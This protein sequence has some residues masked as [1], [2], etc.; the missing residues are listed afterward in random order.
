MTQTKTVEVVENVEDIPPGPFKTQKRFLKALLSRQYLYLMFG[1]AVRCGKTYVGLGVLDDMCTKYPGVRC[2]VVRK[3]LSVIRRNTIPSFK[4]ILRDYGDPK[5]CELNKAE[6]TYFYTNGSELLF[7]EGDIGSDPDLNKFRGFEATI[8]LLEEANEMA[9]AVFYKAIERTGQWMNNEYNIP[10]LVILT[11]NPDKNW[12]KTKFYDPWQNGQL[13]NPEFPDFEKFFFIQSLPQDNPYNSKMYL[14][15]LKAF[16]PA[17]YNRFVKGDWN[18]SDNP[19]QLIRYEWYS[20]CI[21]MSIPDDVLSGARKPKYIG[22]DVA[23]EGDDKTAL[24]YGD[25]NGLLYIEKYTH[26][27][28]WQTG[29][30]VMLRMAELGIPQENIGV[31]AIGVGA[32]VLGYLESKHVYIYSFKSTDGPESLPDDMLHF[33]FRNKRAEAHWL[34]RTAIQN[35]TTDLPPNYELQKQLCVLSY[36]T[37][38]GKITVVDKKTVKNELTYSPDEGDSFVIMHYV[39]EKQNSTRVALDYARKLV[40]VLGVSEHSTTRVAQYKQLV[41]AY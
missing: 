16:P 25:D 32:E 13:G 33:V 39:K 6:W 4:K 5:R 2:V 8:I 23:R 14:E 15:S 26:A 35:G 21:N 7:V 36:N 31:D 34:V 30:V 40:Q 28:G 11:C 20:P 18:F 9:E 17:Q 38:G 1:G 3:S 10:P 24:A 41:G 22:I 12:V 37:D 19:N 27:K 29:D